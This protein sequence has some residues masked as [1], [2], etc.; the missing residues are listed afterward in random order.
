MNDK[1]LGQNTVTQFDQKIK[2]QYT[3]TRLFPSIKNPTRILCRIRRLILRS[4][5]RHL[6]NRSDT[7]FDFFETGGAQSLHSFDNCRGLKLNS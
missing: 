1:N 7:G 6:L 3:Q 2:P 5:R 4:Y